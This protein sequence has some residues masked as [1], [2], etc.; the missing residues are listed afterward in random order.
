MRPPPRG[1]GSMPPPTPHSSIPYRRHPR[2]SLTSP[3]LRI[4]LTR[5]RGVTKVSHDARKM[6]ATT[7]QSRRAAPM[8]AAVQ[9]L[10]SSRG[11]LQDIERID[12]PRR[13]S[14]VKD[15]RK[16]AGRGMH[17]GL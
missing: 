1:A 16:E 15:Q 7:V 14:V 5:K 6:S 9:S 4:A 8:L 17:V 11:G 12:S 13:E 10:A 3:T 2:G